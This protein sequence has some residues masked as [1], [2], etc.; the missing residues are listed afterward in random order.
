MRLFRYFLIMV[1]GAAIGAG[2]WVAWQNL[3]KE[4]PT[5]SFRES[6]RMPEYTPEWITRQGG[7]YPDEVGVRAGRRLPYLVYKWTT[8]PTA[9]FSNYFPMGS[10]ADEWPTIGIS[11]GQVDYQLDVDMGGQRTPVEVDGVQGWFTRLG[12]DELC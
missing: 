12:P 7:D 3:F 6:L 1:V 5:P 8:D 4:S 10:V 2:G 9:D 11:L